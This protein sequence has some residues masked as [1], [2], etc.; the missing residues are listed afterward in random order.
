[1]G[2]PLRLFMSGGFEGDGETRHVVT[3]PT[4][5]GRTDYWMQ[6]TLTLSCHQVLTENL[7]P[8]L[9]PEAD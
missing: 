2:C 8:C 7:H 3:P 1:M 9:L 4:T 5:N 6:H